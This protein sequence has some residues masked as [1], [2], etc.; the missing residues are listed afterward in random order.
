MDKLE[1]RPK[2]A[3]KNVSTAGTWQSDNCTLSPSLCQEIANTVTVFCAACNSGHAYSAPI[4]YALNLSGSYPSNSST[5]YLT[6]P[7][8]M[9]GT[10]NVSFD[11]SVLVAV[12]NAIA[13][14]GIQDQ[15]VKWQEWLHDYLNGAALAL[16]P[17]PMESVASFSSDWAALHSDSVSVQ[18][19]FVCVVEAV[20]S[21]LKV[22][23]TVSH[24]RRESQEQPDRSDAHQQHAAAT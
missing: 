16:N 15:G 23:E 5:V 3:L 18:S 22:L 8:D 20:S 6:S 10:T 11:S 17:M 21:A 13:N 9:G 19:D 7:P 4:Q 12:Q 14:L 24:D 1:H 2:P